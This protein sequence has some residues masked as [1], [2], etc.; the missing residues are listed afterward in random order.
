M[1]TDQYPQ[2]AY[3]AKIIVGLLIVISAC[4][5]ALSLPE[6][7]LSNGLA[8]IGVSVLIIFFI[9]VFPMVY[10]IYGKMDELQKRLHEHASVLTVTLLVSISGI[11]GVLQSNEI[12]PLFNQFGTMAITIAI[13]SIALSFID[14]FYK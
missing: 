10:L 11:L 7:N 1:R 6:L 12:I 4:A 9:A 8:L 14:Q 5:I 13:W 2:I 3:L